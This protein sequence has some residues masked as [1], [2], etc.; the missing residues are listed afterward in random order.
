M[1]IHLSSAAIFLSILLLGSL[2]ANAQQDTSYALSL[3]KSCLL[4][5][6]YRSEKVSVK[7]P[8]NLINSSLSAIYPRE[9]KALHLKVR[10]RSPEGKWSQWQKLAPQHEGNTPGKSTFGPLITPEKFDSLQFQSDQKIEENLTFRVYFAVEQNR[11]TPQ[12]KSLNGSV[13]ACGCDTVAIC[14]RAC[15]CPNNNCPPDPTPVPQKV[16]HFIVH[17]TAGSATNPRA[18]MRAIWDFHVN[19]NGWDDIGYNFLIGENGEIYAGRPDSTR[20]AHFSCMNSQTMGTA[21][22]GNFHRSS[23]TDTAFKALQKLL[24]AQACRFNIDPAGQSMHS[25]SQLNLRH[26]S[27]H[28]DGNVA[29]V[30]CPKGTV[31]PGDSLYPNLPGIINAIAANPCLQGI[32]LQNI[33]SLSK[34]SLYP[35]PAKNELWLQAPEDALGGVW[36]VYNMQGTLRYR[37]QNNNSRLIHLS[38]KNWGK[39]IYLIQYNTRDGEALRQKLIVN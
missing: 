33:P 23:P 36:R 7:Q 29:T 13:N 37:V 6:G 1:K 20:G 8:K 32:G 9:G 39:G 24:T 31:C 3:N 14:P 10:W 22:I 27:G 38:V 19:T 2:S 12:K 5:E 25:S 4:K 16:T 35:N 21:L 17:H 18:V 28:R 30:G 26:I 11:Q 15:W 34:L